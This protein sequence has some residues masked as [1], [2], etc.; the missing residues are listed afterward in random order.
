MI[1]CEFSGIV[2]EAFKKQGHDAWSCDYLDTEIP[3]NHYKGDVRDMLGEKWDIFIA[4]PPC[5]RLAN[6]GVQWLDKRNLW[7]ELKVSASFFSHLLNAPVEKICVENPI[8]HKYALELIGK[9]YDQKIQPW[10]F[11][12]G[13]VKATCLWLKNLPNLVPTCIVDG[14]Q[15]RVLN[16]PD[17]KD[18]WKKRSIS[19][20]GIAEAMATQWGKL[21]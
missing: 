1:G 4:H 17:S 13:E 14:R 12:H 11:G 7:D 19:Y 18:R 9:K 5:T 20:T 8:M 15:S 2:R 16:M 3:G 6:S 21:I 10:Q